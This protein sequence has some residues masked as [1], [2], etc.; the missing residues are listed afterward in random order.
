M[1]SVCVGFLG[2]L[3]VLTKG[4]FSNVYFD[5]LYADVLVLCATAAFGIFS[6]LNKKCNFE[7][8]SANTLFFLSATIFSFIAMVVFSQFTIPSAD[9]LIP[10]I[11]NGFSYVLWAKS[12]SYLKATVIAPLI[13]LTPVL[14]TFLIIIFFNETF[15]PVYTIGLLLVLCAGLLAK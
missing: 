10:V 7:A 4:N 15:L 12:L 2:V 1:L 9:S 3:I 11:I 8:F 14:A 5:N 13:F 6:V